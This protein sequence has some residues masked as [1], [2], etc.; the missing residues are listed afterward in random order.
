M[1]PGPV[2]MSTDASSAPS[3]VGAA[4]G[5]QRDGLRAADCPHLVDAE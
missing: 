1:F 2:I 3:V 4:I 5:Q